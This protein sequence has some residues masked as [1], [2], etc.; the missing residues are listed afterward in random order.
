MALEDDRRK[1]LHPVG[2]KLAWSDL[3]QLDGL[4]VKAKPV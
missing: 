2:D 4:E 1:H 3:A